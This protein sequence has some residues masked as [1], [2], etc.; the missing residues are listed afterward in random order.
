MNPFELLELAEDDNKQPDKSKEQKGAM[1]MEFF[2]KRFAKRETM[3]TG[4]DIEKLPSECQEIIG[5]HH[6]IQQFLSMNAYIA[7]KE[8]TD[9]IKAYTSKRTVFLPPDILLYFF[10]PVSF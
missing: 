5:L 6:L 8:Y 10:I 1:C 9:K 2:K 3:P 7:R 4:S